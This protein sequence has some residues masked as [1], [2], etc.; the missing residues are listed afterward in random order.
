MVWTQ[1]HCCMS[2][3]WEI[4]IFHVIHLVESDVFSIFLLSVHDFKILTFSHYYYYQGKNSKT[5]VITLGIFKG[6][7]LKM[8]I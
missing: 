8:K 7:S 1:Y 4:C 6:I 3:I 2:N 5:P